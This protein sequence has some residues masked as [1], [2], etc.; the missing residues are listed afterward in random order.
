MKAIMSLT[1]AR[2]KIFQLSDNIQKAS[3]Y[4]IF[5]E[6]GRAK[7]VLLS[8]DDFDSWMETMDVIRECPG[9]QE[10]VRQL[11]KDIKSGAAKKYITLEEILVKEG[12]LDKSE[13]KK[14]NA[15]SNKLKR[16]GTKTT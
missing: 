15:I 4:Y 8:A 14:R 6:N 9:I 7:A 2:K 11:E 12:Y 10:D 1:E 5:T 3:N 16:K 13:L